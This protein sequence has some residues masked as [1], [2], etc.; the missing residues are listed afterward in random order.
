MFRLMLAPAVGGY[1][2]GLLS[3]WERP[4]LPLRRRPNQPCRMPN[5]I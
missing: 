4:R 5:V 3:Q 2:P 1:R